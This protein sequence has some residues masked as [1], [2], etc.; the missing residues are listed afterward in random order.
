MFNTIKEASI[1]FNNSFDA[2]RGHVRTALMTKLGVTDPWVKGPWI[3]DLFPASIV[4]QFDNATWRIG[5]TSTANA[6]GTPPTVTIKG[7]PV[8]VHMAFVDNKESAKE[9]L[10]YLLDDEGVTVTQEAA[11]TLVRESLEFCMTSEEMVTALQ[12]GAKKA[13]VTGKPTVIP[14][15]IIQPGWGSSAYYSKEVLQ[16][17]GPIIFKA[18]THMYWNHATEDEQVARP[19]GNLD[20][21]AAVFTEDAAW[22]DNGVKG[23]GLYSSA[24]VFSDYATQV[25]EKGPHIGV[26]INAAIKCH[27]G[28][29]EGRKGN[30]ADKFVYAYSTD[31]VTKAGAGG[32]PIVPVLESER[33]NLEDTMTDE[34]VKALE[35]RNKE[36]DRQ[37][38]ES[39]QRLAALE[40]EKHVAAAVAAVVKELKEADIP[41]NEKLLAR[42]CATPVMKEGKVDPDF[43]KGIV[44]DFSDGHEGR[45]EGMGE[46]KP[47]KESVTVT[48]AKE[49]ETSLQDSLKRLGGMSDDTVK[50]VGRF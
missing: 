31:F 12:E 30:I 3:V 20:F 41:F 47:A 14:I 22:D 43:I 25:A 40:S 38:K 17:D 46:R 42:A 35:D 50:T 4:Y 26:S 37:L 32:A 21:L 7:D 16:R 27:E 44:A 33:R 36:L 45:V 19:A 8:K 29:V 23:P 34:Q 28:T 39:N 10:S 6:A 15:K 48:Q 13:S 5:Y 49:A 9:Y 1:P 2:L 18:G 24:K 11:P